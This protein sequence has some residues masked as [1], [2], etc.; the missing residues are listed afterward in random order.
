MVEISRLASRQLFTISIRARYGRGHG[1]LNGLG[2]LP[3]SL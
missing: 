1:N 2:C 3:P